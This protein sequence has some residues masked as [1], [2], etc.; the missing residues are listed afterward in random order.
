MFWSRVA[1]VAGGLALVSPV[2][3]ADVTPG[4]GSLKDVPFVAPI[5]TPPWAGFYAGLHVGGIVDDNGRNLKVD[6]FE[7]DETEL[8]FVKRHII[9]DPNFENE[10][11]TFDRDDDGN[12][13]GG[14]HIGYNWQRPDSLFVFGVEGDLDFADRLDFL[15]TL[16]ARLGIGLDRF[17][18]YGTAG[19]A[20]ASFDERRFDVVNVPVLLPAFDEVVRLRHDNDDTQ[21]GF[22]AGVGAE[23]KL[24][25]NVSLGLE[26]LYYDFD[27]DNRNSVK[28]TRDIDDDTTEVAVFSRHRDNSFWQVRG[29]LTYHVNQP[30]APLR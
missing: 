14:V 25:Q 16:R 9:V 26:G 8:G 1:C 12:V 3:A 5:I 30:F 23:I 7:V 4:F 28:F 24:A 2:M 20:F 22:V 10:F 13:I 29:R 19:V 6:R 18:I 17:L 11:R 21:V 15:A 27:D